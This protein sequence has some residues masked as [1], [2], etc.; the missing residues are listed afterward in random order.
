MTT[1]KLPLP[2]L[3]PGQSAIVQVAG[4]NLLLCRS[5][6]GLHAMAETCPHQ[7]KSLEGAR[8]RGNAVMCPHHGARFS[9]EDGRSLSPQLTPDG[10][11]LLP[12]R[13]AGEEVE[14]EL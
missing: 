11:N 13:E 9:L 7:E 3:A 6:S 1:H 2:A 8:V 12:C 4:R 5:A 10:V 14:I